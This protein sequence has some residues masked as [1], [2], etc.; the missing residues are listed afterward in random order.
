VKDIGIHALLF[1]VVSFAIVLLGS[2]YADAEDRPALK[3][4][5]RRLLVFLAGCA[6][7]AGIM[8]ILEHT[9]AALD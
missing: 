5:P 6:V 8:L 4:L 3:V 9:V 7:L 1:V 2:F